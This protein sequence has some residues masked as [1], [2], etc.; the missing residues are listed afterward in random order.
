MK[1]KDT[2]FNLFGTEYTI[3]YVDKIEDKNSRDED[4]EIYGQT[5]YCS[6]EIKIAKTVYGEKQPLEEMRLTLL[7]EIMHAIFTSGQYLSCSS[8]EPLVE[9]V[10]RCL[11]QLIKEKII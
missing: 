9:W 10:S 6:R 11:N 3:K 5:I 2:K 4:V 1:L 8:D 7:H